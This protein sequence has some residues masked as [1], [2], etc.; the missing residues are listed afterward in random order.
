MYLIQLLLPLYDNDGESLPKSLFAEVRDELV[1]QFG[2]LTAY[3][4]APARG[5]WCEDDD[6]TVRDDLIIHEVMAEGIDRT[7]WA[8][9]RTSLEARL[10]Q[11]QIMIRAH[12]VEVL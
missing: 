9:Y 7:W 6:E 11:E 5:L 2:G 4:R 1:Q 12:R 10:R 3:S 8:A